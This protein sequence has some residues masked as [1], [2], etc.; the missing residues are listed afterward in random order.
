MPEISIIVPVYNV[1]KYIHRCINNILA[2]TFTDFELILV[3][4]GSPDN[5]GIFCDN[6]A[7]LDPRV[8]VIHQENA[9]VSTARNKGLN[10]AVG[11]YVTF[12]DS[13]DWIPDNYLFELYHAC[14]Q[15]LSQVAICDYVLYSSNTSQILVSATEHETCIMTNREAIDFYGNL[16]L[17]KANALFRAPWAKLIKTEIAKKHLFP[18]DRKYAEDAACVYRWLWDSNRV[19]HTNKTKY[20]YYQNSD[21]ACNQSMDL[22]VLG[23]FQSEKE[24]IDFFKKNQFDVLY[25]KTCKRYI[26]DYSWAMSKLKNASES[27]KRELLKTLRYGLR[28]YS[29]QAGITVLNNPHFY[30]IAYPTEMKVYWYW[31]AIK[32]KLKRKK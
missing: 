15:N 5:S 29:K 14:V 7:C 32:R 27:E 22:S 17:E 4:D 31:Q 20:Y 13:D 23:N 12:I 6:Y 11:E 25:K 21:G 2:Q 9:G 3:D 18:E 24:W 10:Q 30:E 16:N 19:I 8:K 26:N 1:E 28:H